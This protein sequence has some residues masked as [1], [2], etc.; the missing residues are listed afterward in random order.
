[1]SRSFLRRL[2]FLLPVL[3]VATGRDGAQAN[4]DPGIDLLLGDVSNLTALGRNGLFPNGI[5]G[6]GF[7]SCSQII[8]VIGSG[9]KIVEHLGHQQIGIRIKSTQELITLIAQVTFNLNS[10][11]N[12]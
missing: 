12:S 9:I 6:C 11:L 4:A 8:I 7:Q 2:S 5:S 1:M 3:F 10:G